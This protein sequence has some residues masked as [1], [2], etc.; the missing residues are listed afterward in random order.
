MRT[1]TSPS[2]LRSWRR[3]WRPSRW[4]RTRGGSASWRS[5]GASLCSA[6]RRPPWRR[7][8]RAAC[9]ARA[10]RPC[11]RSRSRLR[12]GRHRVQRQRV[13]GRLAGWRRWLGQSRRLRCAQRRQQQPRTTRISSSSSSSSG[14]SPGCWIACPLR[15]PTRVWQVGTCGGVRLGHAAGPTGP[16]CS[17]HHAGP[18]LLDCW[19]HEE[20]RVAPVHSRYC[21]H[22][23]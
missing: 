4:A 5:L 17:L 19:G 2:P 18:C 1:H 20:R 6:G 13:S 23:Y 7:V 3:R 14:C 8:C 9:P 11:S 21:S 22:A 15:P 16:A 10:P 12:R